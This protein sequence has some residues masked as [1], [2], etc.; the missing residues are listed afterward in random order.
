MSHDSEQTLQ[1]LRQPIATEGLPKLS[2]Q[3]LCSYKRQEQH[4]P[5]RM[6]PP[7]KPLRLSEEARRLFNHRSD[8][9]LPW[10]RR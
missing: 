6:Q 10:R 3:A 2:V 8:S 7:N 1:E 5:K 9:N 4:G